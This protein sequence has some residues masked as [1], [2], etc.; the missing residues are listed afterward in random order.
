LE[1]T[2]FLGFI[3]HFVYVG[4]E[5]ALNRRSLEK[6]GQIYIVK[7]GYCDELEAWGDRFNDGFKHK[8]TGVKESLPLALYKGW[9]RIATAEAEIGIERVR[10]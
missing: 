7:F 10:A 9:R 6:Y 3:M 1:E 2:L 8:E 4:F 5:E